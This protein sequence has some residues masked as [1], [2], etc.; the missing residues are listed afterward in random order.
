MEPKY[1]CNDIKKN[2]FYKVYSICK[3]ITKNIKEKRNET[4]ANTFWKPKV[5]TYCIRSIE[6]YSENI[7]QKIES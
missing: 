2:L 5:Y 1:H 6:I 4:Q 3:I 7:F